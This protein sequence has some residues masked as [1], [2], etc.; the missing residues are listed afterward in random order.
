MYFP[1]MCCEYSAEPCLIIVVANQ[2][3][4]L[5]CIDCD[6]EKLVMCNQPSALE[7]SVKAS[8]LCLLFAVVIVRWIVIAEAMTSRRLIEN[9]PRLS[10]GRL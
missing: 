5:L 8:I 4:T 10:G 9:I 7:P 6:D 3:A 1:G 2:L